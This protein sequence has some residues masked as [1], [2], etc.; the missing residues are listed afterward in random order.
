MQS[1]NKVGEISPA[2]N[3]TILKKPLHKIN[4]VLKISAII[5]TIIFLSIITAVSLFAGDGTRFMYISP[6]PFWVI[7]LL[8]IMQYGANE[9]IAAAILSSVFLL[10]GNLPEQFLTETMYEY[11]LRVLSLPFIWLVTALILGSVRTRQLNDQAALK[12]K[13]EKAE[14]VIKTISTGYNS[15][16]QSKEQ[17]EL[18]L[19]SE[20]CS[21]LTISEISRSLQT[22]DISKIPAAIARL[23]DVV[24]S[25]AKF[26]IFF[27]END[28]LCLHKSYGWKK[29]DLYRT[30]LDK[31]SPLANHILNKL[32][33]SLCVTNIEEEPILMGQGIM[34]GPILDKR[35]G[36]VFGMLK[37]EEM[38]FMNMGAHTRETFQL[39]CE[40]ISS[41]YINIDKKR[42]A[43]GSQDAT[44]AQ[45]SLPQ[46]KLY[47]A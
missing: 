18:R 28:D 32:T 45:D 35:S 2:K 22:S 14:R 21:L 27:E 9:A 41:V 20:K 25:P 12:D 29:T 17:L 3:S 23:V 33:P 39:L 5:E 38:S 11:I 47:A 7:I 30:I 46:E 19:A 26:S 43:S 24:L 40:W 36:K 15:V 16:K 8:V 37:I 31:D 34:A 10:F 44:S 13:L 1:S 4:N 6:H 42:I